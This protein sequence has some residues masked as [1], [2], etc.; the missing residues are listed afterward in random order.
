MDIKTITVYKNVEHYSAFPSV[1]KLENGEL[2]IVFRDAPWRG[3]P[4]HIDPESKTTIVRSKDNGQTWE[5]TGEVVSGKSTVGLQDPSIM[6]MKDGTLILSSFDWELFKTEEEVTARG[7]RYSREHNYLEYH[8]ASVIGTHIWRSTDNGN[9]WTES[10]M[11]ITSV[12]PLELIATSEPVVETQPGE[13]LIPLYGHPGN[14]GVVVLMSSKDKGNTWTKTGEINTAADNPEGLSEPALLKLP[15][16]NILCIMRPL[17]VGEGYCYQS[18][19]A[20]NG[21][22][23]STPIRTPF[24]GFPASLLLLKNSNVLCAYGYRR[25]PFGVRSCISKDGGKT[26][27]MERENVLRTDGS[28]S[29]LGYPSSVELPDGSIFTAYYFHDENKTRYIGAGIYKV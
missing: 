18:V 1:V 23:W 20:D 6:Q 4:S 25:K 16:G 8:R 11:V 15:D 2:L 26:W 7:I 3:K 29:D 5:K 19:S 22:T 12:D 28:G 17:P 13:L 24:W 21:K 9:T 27:D 10:Q 14:K